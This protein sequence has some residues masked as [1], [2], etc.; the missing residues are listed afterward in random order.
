MSQFSFGHVSSRLVIKALTLSIIGGALAACATSTTNYASDVSPEG[1][2]FGNY[3]AGTYANYLDDADA[4]SH[5]YGEAFAQLPHDVRL[6]RRAV[7]SAVTAGDIDKAVSLANTLLASGETES[8]A[9]AVLG[10]QALR[11]AQY[12]KAIVYFDKETSDLTVS[13]LSKLMKGW[14]QYGAGD[15]ALARETFSKL[16]GGNYFSRFGLLQIAEL[17][18]L[19]GDFDKAQASIDE[20][21]RQGAETLDLEKTLFVSRLVSAQGQLPEALSM[22]EKYSKENGGFETGPVANAIERLKN[23]KSLDQITSSQAHAARALTQPA[24]GFFAQNRALD[25]AEVFLRIALNQD[26]QYHKGKLWLGDVL[27]AYERDAE[28]MKQYDDIPSSSPYFVSSQLS[29]G[30]MLVRRDQNDKALKVFTDVHKKFPSF[31][32]RDALGRAHLSQENYAAA[33]PIYEALVESLSEE[34]LKQDPQALYLR[35]ICYEREGQ[36]EKAVVDFKR[37]L[38]YK[39]DNADAL[40]YLGYT[41]V[42]RGENLTEAFRMIRRAVELE[43]DSGA[44][45]DSLGWAHYKLGQYEEAKEKLESAVVLSPYSA[46]II[47]HLG[48]VYWKLGRKKE[49][50]YQW[51]RALAFDPTDEEIKTI[52]EKLKSGLPLLQT[53]P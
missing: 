25:A 3:L 39:P 14:A 29:K 34:E 17:D 10:A 53:A 2:L 44:I 13:I 18:L 11:N 22:L 7:T 42:D 1:R 32:T 35:G 26:P 4:R 37:V 21:D 41:W 5:Y 24:Y 36:W 23:G 19:T 40:N 9:Y 38:D 46:T 51:E 16:P 30:Y 12:D 47:D 27:S 6:G 52:N 28:A 31:V 48:D 33:L 15:P 43:P 50:S 49:A 20:L 45:V 8:M